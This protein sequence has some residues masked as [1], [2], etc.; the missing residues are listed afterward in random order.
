MRVVITMDRDHRASD[1]VSELEKP[2]GLPHRLRLRPHLLVRRRLVLKDASLEG[3]RVVGV[4]LRQQ[5]FQLL[6][7]IG[8]V[9]A[10]VA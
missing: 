5:L 10:R 9:R 2:A 8:F 6:E 1:L 4:G 7:N 3:E